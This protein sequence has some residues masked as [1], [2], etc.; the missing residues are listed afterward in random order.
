MTTSLSTTF[1]FFF[2]KKWFWCVAQAGLMFMVLLMLSPEFWASNVC[3]ALLL[4]LCRVCFLSAAL[5][6]IPR[7]YASWG[8]PTAKLKINVS[9]VNY[10]FYYIE[11]MFIISVSMYLS[12][13][14]TGA[15]NRVLDSL[16][17]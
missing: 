16:E 8:P 5:V 14:P 4:S 10:F 15:R 9:P 6:T 1:I 7:D 12:P 2:F 11:I 3:Q 17:L 13:V